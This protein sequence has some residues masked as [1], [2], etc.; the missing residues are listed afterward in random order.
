MEKTLYLI[1]FFLFVNMNIFSQTTKEIAKIGIKSTVSIVALDNINQPLGYGSGFIIGNGLI[2]T[3]VHVIE[4]SSSAYVLLNGMEK[5]Y[6][7]DGFIAIDKENDLVILK[8][9]EI[10]G[11]VLELGSENLPEIGEKI[12]AVGNPKGL[13]GTFSE[14]I[15]SGV[16]DL[17]TSQVL[18]ITAPISPGSSG[19]PVLDSNG[20]VIGIAFASFSSGQ[21]L[22]FA[23]PVKYLKNIKSLISSLVSISTLKPKQ[24]QKN[25]TNTVTSN[26]KEGISIR[27][28][29]PCFN[30]APTMIFFS[31]KNNLP[32]TVCDISILF[33]VFDTS[34]T[35]VDYTEKT[36]F[37]SKWSSSYDKKG[38][39]PFL[40]SSIDFDSHD[41]SA[42]EVILKAGYKVKTRILDFKILEE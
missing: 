35:V 26:I 12:Y 31:I 22:N 10:Y 30:C 20:K 4:G 42:P 9:P 16:R 34:G 21:N 39:K 11:D 18:Q 40:A 5:K 37:N 28:V 24:K 15:I 32:Y 13:N 17:S 33:L 8:V 29:S 6:K 3:N 25:N 14:G 7:V 19:G 38:I 27:N 41:E 23:I 2:A 36:F 1:I